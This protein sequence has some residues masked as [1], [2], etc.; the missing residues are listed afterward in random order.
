MLAHWKKVFEKGLRKF[1]EKKFRGKKFPPIDPP[2]VTDITL[3]YVFQTNSGH[4][5]SCMTGNQ[6]HPTTITMKATIF[7]FLWIAM[8]HAIKHVPAEKGMGVIPVPH[9]WPSTGPRDPDRFFASVCWRK[10]IAC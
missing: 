5:S 6:R 9:T 8:V 2:L 4:F 3:E 7:V 10:S 1:S